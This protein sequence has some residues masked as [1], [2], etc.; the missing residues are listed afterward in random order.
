MADAIPDFSKFMPSDDSDAD[1]PD[2]PSLEDIDASPALPAPAPPPALRPA[3]VPHRE[4]LADFIG[5][6]SASQDPDEEPPVDTEFAQAELLAV[7]ARLNKSGRG[8]YVINTPGRRLIREGSLFK[9]GA[10]LFALIPSFLNIIL[11]Y[12]RI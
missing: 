5:A 7:D 10:L 1:E 2:I 11:Q 3:V 4:S 9:K 8:I 6:A 12:L